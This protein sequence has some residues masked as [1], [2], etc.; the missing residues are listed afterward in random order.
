M[1]RDKL[2]LERAKS[3]RRKP[4]S[5]EQSLWLAL[6]ARRLPPAKFRRQVVVG[7]YIVDFACRIPSMLAIEIDGDSHAMQPDCDARREAVLR[8]KGYDIL[9]FTN[10]EVRQNL[11]GVLARISQVLQLPLSPAL[12]PEGEREK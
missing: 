12:S 11:E 6:R 2:L 5:A 7:P 9:R 4:T 1:A 8:G 10:A 3:M